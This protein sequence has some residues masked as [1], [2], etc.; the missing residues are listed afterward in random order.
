MGEQVSRIKKLHSEYEYKYIVPVVVRLSNSDSNG[1]V[2]AYTLY[3]EYSGVL[4]VESS[5]SMGLISYVG[6][7]YSE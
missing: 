2:F 1:P 5:C 3:S 4:R 7:M 6:G